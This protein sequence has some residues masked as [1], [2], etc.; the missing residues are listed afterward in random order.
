M[1]TALQIEQHPSGFL[2]FLHR[3]RIRV[4]Y[5]YCDTA[6]VK[7]VTYEHYH[8]KVNWTVIDRFVKAQRN[9][10]LCAPSLALPA[11]SGYKRFHSAEL[12]RRM[13]ENAAVFLLRAAEFR[14]V[15]AVLIDNSG[16]SVGLCEYLSDFC[17]PVY[18][19]TAATEIYAAQAEYLL[20][21]RGA[22]LRI[23]GGTDCLKD[24]DLIIAPEKLTQ[25][26]P[27]PTYSLILTGEKPSA[28]QNT[29]AISDYFI[30]LPSKYKELCPG[31]L[32][33]MYFASALFAL[34]GARELG[35]EIFHRCGDGNT[36]H[37]RGSLTALFRKRLD[38]R[39]KCG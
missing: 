37:T 5:R 21:E 16:D 11:D 33:E 20:N 27:C 10:V 32:D 7:C 13:C 29:T 2:R 24:A 26:L 35:G 34:T 38:C 28:Q 30:E 23:C 12:S 39:I 6:A 22:A 18:V 1:M 14:G 36:L 8:G 31:D 15:K 3:N 17:D 4:D 19:V 9:R 25:T